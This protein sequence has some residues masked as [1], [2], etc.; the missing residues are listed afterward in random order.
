MVHQVCFAGLQL[1]SCRGYGLFPSTTS[2]HPYL[3][4]GRGAQAVFTIRLLP[5]QLPASHQPTG[6]GRTHK[7]H[8]GLVAILATSLSQGP[9]AWH[10]S[11]PII[12]PGACG[13]AL[14]LSVPRCFLHTQSTSRALEWLIHAPLLPSLHHYMVQHVRCDDRRRTLPTVFH[15]FTMAL[16]P[17]GACSSPGPSCMHYVD[18]QFIGICISV[19]DVSKL[20]LTILTRRFISSLLSTVR[21]P[22][23]PACCMAP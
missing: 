11:G 14:Y 9:S 18:I 10:Y 5:L 12:R 20:P 17:Y 6:G 3:P 13:P 7:Q 15:C 19:L 1:R 2:G 16:T 22:L 4:K 8:A 23:T 21:D